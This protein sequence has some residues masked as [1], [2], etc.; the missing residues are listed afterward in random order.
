MMKRSAGLELSYCTNVHPGESWCELRQVLE[1]SVAA[2]KHRVCPHTSFGLGLRLSNRAVCELSEGRPREQFFETLERQKLYVF[3]LNGFPYGA[4]HGTRVKEQVYVPD[5]SDP[6]RA[7]YTLRLAELL[8]QALP[9][10]VRYGSIST[11]PGCFSAMASEPARRSIVAALVHMAAE[12]WR[13]R[14]ET[15]KHIVLA[16]EPEPMC[17]LETTDE[18]VAFFET[19]LWSAAALC[20]FRARTGLSASQAESAIRDHLGV[21][22][23]V[24]HVAVEYENA[25]QVLHR[26]RGA[27]IGVAKVQISAALMLVPTP[28]S[29]SLLEAFADDVYLHQVVVRGHD[30]RLSR[31]LDLPDALRSE[32]ARGAKQWRVHFHVPVFFDRIGAFETTRFELETVLPLLAREPICGHLEVETYSWNM[33]PSHLRADTLVN[34]IARELEWVQGIMV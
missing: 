6:E 19:M 9:S 3:T 24:C 34:D 7:A 15:G 10:H 22:I 20:D 14:Q 13:L 16:L 21:C 32:A 1:T 30:D 23:D 33:L 8:A 2:V 4:F 27:G 25:V 18:T 29:L 17:L 5:W 31:F 11:V 28:A 26:L 12:L